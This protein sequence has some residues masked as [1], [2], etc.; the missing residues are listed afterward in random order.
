MNFFSI[1]KKSLFYFIPPVFIIGGVMSAYFFMDF[2]EEKRLIAAKEELNVNILEHDIQNDLSNIADDLRLLSSHFELRDFL[3]TDS[4][5]KL[6]ALIEEFI[7][8]SELKKIFDQ[9]RLLDHSGLEVVRISYRGGHAE[10]VPIEGLQNRNKHYFNKIQKLAEGEVYLS[11]FD[12]EVK[13]N[14]IGQPVKTI[15]RVGIPL[16]DQKGRRKGVLL[17]NILSSSFLKH[18]SGHASKE[19][20]HY[21]FVGSDNFYF[22]RPEN[23]SNWRLVDTYES[24]PF[25][26]KYPEVWEKIEQEISGQ[27]F[28]EKGVVT[29]ESIFPYQAVKPDNFPRPGKRKTLGNDFEMERISWKLISIVPTEFLKM[30]TKKGLK[31][32][33]SIFFLFTLVMGVGSFSL[34]RTSLQRKISEE[35]CAESEERYRQLIENTLYGIVEVDTV[36]TI[37][38]ANTSYHHLLGYLPGE[39]LGHNIKK[40]TPPVSMEEPES[41]I[42]SSGNRSSALAEGRLLKNDGQ[43]ID[44]E[45]A[46]SAKCSDEGTIIGFTSVI[47]DISKRKTAEKRIEKALLEK[48][49]LLRE[50]HHRVKNNLQIIRSLLYLQAKSVQGKRDRAK[51]K[52]AQER[53]QTMALLHEQLYQSEDVA[54]V[55]FSE[56][57]NQ[58]VKELIKSYNVDENKVEISSNIEEIAL[59]V[60]LAI[61]CGLIINELLSNI[62]K[63]A[64]PEERKGKVVISCRAKSEGFELRISDDGVGLPHG[65]DI[66]NS[67]TLGLR[68][69]S[70]LAEQIEGE[71]TLEESKG[72]SYQVFF[73]GT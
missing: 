3:N 35:E 64:F 13:D 25:H 15:F 2:G 19:S 49:V 30:G 61:P 24:E 46:R 65:F 23:A 69:V 41:H 52:E 31:R 11:P 5:P 37:V 40:L 43:V 67:E 9:V 72:T 71:V 4:A 26:L 14:D 53:V 68:L 6:D 56:Y 58:I 39:L 50:I 73:R 16:F 21:L 18:L 38:F 54:R 36:G 59:G 8:F 32:L 10:P 55:H 45:V 17:L 47:A 60:D 51:F 7:S 22:S 12:F 29:F 44:V 28:T 62:F 42:A 70:L 66:K 33:F 48:E 63:H 57:I 1:L 34:A 27:F 20:N